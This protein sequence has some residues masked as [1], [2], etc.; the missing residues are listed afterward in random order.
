MIK[1]HIALWQF[2]AGGLVLGVIGAF[3]VR[4]RDFK[5]RLRRHLMGR[6]HPRS[7]VVTRSCPA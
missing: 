6:R 4:G 5:G 3:A 7:D 2:L 1:L